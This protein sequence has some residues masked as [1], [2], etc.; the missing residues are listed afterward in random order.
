[1]MVRIMR[2]KRW[3]QKVMCGDG[4]LVVR[5]ASC[6]VPA[7]LLAALQVHD[8]A[9]QEPE[10]EDVIRSLF[11]GELRDSPP[12]G[13]STSDGTPSVEPLGSGIS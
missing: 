7:R 3:W 9:I 8:L 5:P 10:V 11:S 13:D 1:M 2:R 12:G 4:V 6:G